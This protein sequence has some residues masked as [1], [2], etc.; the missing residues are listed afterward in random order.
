MRS[1]LLLPLLASTVISL[2]AAAAKPRLT[3][4]VLSQVPQK[5]DIQSKK[6]RY[7][8]EELEELVGNCGP[9][10]VAGATSRTGSASTNRCSFQ[11]KLD[12]LF[13]RAPEEKTGFLPDPDWAFGDGVTFVEPKVGELPDSFDLRDLMKGGQPELKKQNCGDCWAWATHHGLELARAVHDSVAVDHSVQSVLSCSGEGS[14]RGGYMSAVDFLRHGLPHEVDFPYAGRDTKCKYSSS[15][16]AAG[17]DAKTI[18]TPYVGNSLTHSRANHLATGIFREG[19]KVQQMMAAIY[20]WKSPLVVTVAAYSMSGSGI[21]DSCSAINSDGNHMVVITGWDTVDGKRI[22]HVWNSWGKSHGNNGVSRIQWECGEGRLNRGLGQLA[23]IV[24]YRP[25]CTPPDANQ[26][27]LHEIMQ[28]QSVAIGTAQ[29]PGATCSWLPT[30]GLSDP[31]S[32]VTSASP[33]LSTEYH[34]SVQNPC[35]TSS[36]MTLVY[37]WGVNRNAKVEKVRTVFGDAVYKF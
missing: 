35:G 25:A 19:N 1:S 4:E 36:S 13:F 15:D 37:V 12:D 27:Y 18:G 6:Y 10:V 31:N 26:D 9:G 32:C 11:V 20:Q 22:A 14:C 7:A 30:Q 24:Q 29:A 21:Y 8:K 23:K 16:M 34:L 28:G 5:Y 3:A 33:Q 17:W 2:T